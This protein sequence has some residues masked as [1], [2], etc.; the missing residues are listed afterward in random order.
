[1]FCPFLDGRECFGML[2]RPQVSKVPM[3]FRNISMWWWL[4]SRMIHDTSLPHSPS[5]SIS[6]ASEQETNEYKSQPEGKAHL[7]CKHVLSILYLL[8][9]FTLI[10]LYYLPFFRPG[11]WDTARVCKWP[12]I[13]QSWHLKRR[14]SDAST[15][16]LSK[17]TPRVSYLASEQVKFQLKPSMFIYY[18]LC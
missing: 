8:T 2:S 1:M 17:Y 9:H 7:W 18:F 6:L 4:W 16:L 5:F 15:S 3:L 10:Q 12:S 13:M 11:N 14:Q